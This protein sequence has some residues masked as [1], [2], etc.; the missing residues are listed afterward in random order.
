VKK[1]SSV[2]ASQREY[3]LRPF[4]LVNHTHP[5]VY[6]PAYATTAER[7]AILGADRWEGVIVYVEA[8]QTTY[9]LRGGV[10]NDDWIVLVA[11]SGGA[12]HTT[13]GDIGTNTH[14]AIDSHIADSTLH[15][16]Q[17]AI[18][19]TIS[20]ISDF[21]S[22][23][24]ASHTHSYL[25]L[26]ATATAT[27]A[28]DTTGA[29]VNVASAAPPTTGQV[30]RATSATTATWQN[31]AGDIVQVGTPLNSYIGYFTGDKNLTGD[32]GFTWIT[33]SAR[34]SVI[35]S[36]PAI[37]I[38]DD[39][40]AAA[41]MTSVLEFWDST[42]L[43][44][45]MAFASGNMTIRN[46]AGT[47]ILDTAGSATVVISDDGDLAVGGYLD[48]YGGTPA[49]GSLLTWVTANSRAEFVVAPTGIVPDGTPLE[50][51]IVVFTSATNADG[52]TAFTWDGSILT[53]GTFILNNS[54]DQLFI[55]DG[56]L[57]S[58]GLEIDGSVTATPF[59]NLQQDS[60][61]KAVFRY[62]NANTRAEISSAADDITLRPGNV[63]TYIFTQAAMTAGNYVFNIDETVGASQD[64][65]FLMYDD[66]SGEIGLQKAVKPTGTPV[67][68]QIAVW[69]ADDTL[70]GD[71]NFV[72]NGAGLIL[73]GYFISTAIVCEET[74]GERFR[75]MNNY[76]EY[77]G[78]SPNFQFWRHDD[79][80]YTTIWGGTYL[81][82]GYIDIYSD[83][84][85]GDL[86]FGTAVTFAKKDVWHWD[87]SA[88]SH[89]FYSG[90]GGTK[91]LALTLDSNQ[92]TTVA[93]N[94]ISQ[95]GR[96]TNTTRVT[97]TYQILVTDTVVLANTDG[98]TYVTTLPVG[99]QGQSIRVVNT[100]TS[101]IL[102][103]LAPNGAE[104]LIGVN[105]NFTLFDGE[106]LELV[107]D[108]T[109]G[110]Y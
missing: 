96:I 60:V 67:D 80:G 16:T 106:S 89:L 43:V 8:D 26:T 87:E 18:S 30:L 75:V 107:Y 88:G 56:T 62:S 91:P 40:S 7:D 3:I 15:F 58:P 90:A 35:G 31:A 69:T 94:L 13:L 11:A 101:G 73:T 82:G 79:V 36:S 53:A 77:G 21:G 61:T 52:S 10:S 51:Q 95:A 33:A 105:S 45:H 70:E 104:L 44:G 65:L 19:I 55:G 23:A 49:D 24:D 28:L 29:V 12:S 4:A 6:P 42:A 66:A 59:I 81:K 48:G 20:Q 108:A 92:G 47:I 64:N 57:S 2:L 100:G 76:V 103:T 14:A 93:G 68:D 97:T 39:D 46:T 5:A 86:H 1:I 32:A 50:D 109:E 54:N 78:D 85:G 25:G 34:M 98:G 41:A 84:E 63:D 38:Q 9:Q 72:W 22:Y 71:S 83:T 37:R 110:W 74:L 27:T 17:A 99:A 102:L